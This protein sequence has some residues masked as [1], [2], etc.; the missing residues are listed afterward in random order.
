MP[1]EIA[2][3]INISDGGCAAATCQ[4]PTASHGWNSCTRS[5]SALDA[6]LDNDAYSSSR[7]SGFAA[8]CLRYLHGWADGWVGCVRVGRGGEGRGGEGS[9]EVVGGVGWRRVVC[10]LLFVEV[11]WLC[12][13]VGVGGVC[14]CVFWCVCWW[15][16]GGV[17]GLPMLFLISPKKNECPPGRAGVRP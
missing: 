13:C 6:A 15:C 14:V 5:S 3:A 9:E 16:V 2:A 7:S 8:A 11:C 10:C 1:V 4:R 17:C 12:V